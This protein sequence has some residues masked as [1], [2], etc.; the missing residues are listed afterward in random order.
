MEWWSPEPAAR[1]QAHPEISINVDETQ[2]RCRVSGLAAKTMV[3]EA[4]TVQRL[5][6]EL[7]LTSHHRK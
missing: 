4:M 6:W 5:R 2:V 3:K 1:R 7:P